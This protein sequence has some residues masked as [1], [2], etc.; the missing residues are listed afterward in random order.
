LTSQLNAA[1]DALVVI[2]FFA[3]WCG[4]CKVIAPKLEEFANAYSGKV[5]VVKVNN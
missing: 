5:I 1:G 2:D 4:P 3:T